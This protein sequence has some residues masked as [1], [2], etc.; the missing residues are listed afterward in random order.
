MIV[1]NERDTAIPNRADDRRPSCRDR[2]QRLV[3]LTMEIITSLLGIVL[4]VAPLALWV[5]PTV[6]V[7]LMVLCTTMSAVLGLYVLDVCRGE[8][9]LARRLL[10]HRRP[11]ALSDGFLVEL[12]K[13]LPL[14]HHNRR[15]G[16]PEF[17]RKMDR[18]KQ[19]LTT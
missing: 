8:T 19:H 2:R 12:L 16:D 13:L 1:D 17:Q 14:T 7:F 18:L 5:A 15:P 3:G 11:V 4:A 9:A 10:Q 6:P